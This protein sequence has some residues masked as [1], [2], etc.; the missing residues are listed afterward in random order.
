MTIE[1]AHRHLG[2]TFQEEAE[3]YA[4]AECKAAAADERA[5][6]ILTDAEL[7][8]NHDA[9]WELWTGKDDRL[10]EYA[11][12]R[13]FANLPQARKGEQ[14]GIDAITAALTGLYGIWQARIAKDLEDA[15]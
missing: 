4:I 2:Q 3:E 12:A 10:M 14:I 6:S 15:E 13:C 9:D 1:L 5:H 7:L 8:H 11:L